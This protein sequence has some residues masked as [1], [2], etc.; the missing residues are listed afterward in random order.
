MI[1]HKDLLIEFENLIFD[2]HLKSSALLI[3]VKIVQ[4]NWNKNNRMSFELDA[5]RK[6]LK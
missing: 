5:N 1:G 2:Q 3:K 4:I 6:N